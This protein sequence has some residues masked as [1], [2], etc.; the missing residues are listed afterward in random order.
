VLRAIEQVWLKT[1][2]A[3]YWDHVRD[4]IAP[5]VSPQGDIAT[6]SI[7]E[8]NLDQINPG[9]TLYRMYEVTGDER[10]RK[11]LALLCT[12]LRGQP[13]TREGG[14]WHKQI[15]PYQMWLDGIYMASPFYAQYGKTFGEPEAFDDV[16]FQIRAIARHTRDAQTGLFYHGWDES[17]GQKWANP[18]TGCS[19][20]FWGRAVGWYAMA[21]VDVLDYL[22]ADHRGRALLIE[23]L[24][25]LV[26]ALARVQDPATGLWYQVLDQEARA[27]NYLEA[28]G[29]CMFVYSIAK[30][31]RMGYLAPG[32]LDLARRGYRGI[33]GNLIEIDDR[34]LVNLTGTCGGAGLGGNPYRDGS[35]EYYCREKIVANDYKGVGPFILASVEMEQTLDI[36]AAGK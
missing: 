6:Y 27:G 20:H 13:R 18:A 14:F 12:Q 21:L 31:V 10:Y 25:R 4:T 33:L 36:S 8:Y 24:D 26:D 23:I 9:R 3:C 7:A 28:S 15:Y 5:F 35:F 19:P 30:G 16:V 11:A 2:M 34:G 32:V 22:P 17:R 1:G 29:S